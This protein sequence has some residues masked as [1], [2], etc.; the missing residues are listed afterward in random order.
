VKHDSLTEAL[1]E[2][3]SRW[4]DHELINISTLDGF[5]FTYGRE[6]EHEFRDFER[7]G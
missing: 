2:A 1:S 7:T 6:Y 3:L 4:P 5:E